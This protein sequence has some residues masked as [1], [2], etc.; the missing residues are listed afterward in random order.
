MQILTT[1]SAL[2][3]IATDCL[4]VHVNNNKKLN[5][6]AA[7][8]DLATNGLIKETLKLG[9]FSGKLGESRLLTHHQ[10]IKAKRLL[11]IGCGD[12]KELSAREFRQVAKTAFSALIQTQ[13]KNAVTTLHQLAVKGHHQDWATTELLYLGGDAL[14]EFNEFRSSKTKA[15]PFSK[16]TLHCD[17]AN[18]AATKKLAQK[19]GHILHG[20]TL[21][22]NLGNTP[23]NICNPTYLAEQAKQLAKEFD[24][25]SLEVIDEEKAR[26]MGMGSFC[27][28][29]QG[30]DTPGKII[31]MKYKGTKKANAQP[32]TLVGKG[33]TFD[34]GGNCIKQAMPMYDMKY[35]MCGAA[36]VFGVIKACAR[37]KLPIN[38]IGAVAAAENMLSGRAS[39]PSDIVK[40]YS[41][42]TIEITNTDAEGRLVLCDTLTY[43]GKFKPSQV[44]SVATLTGAAIT[45]LGYET[46]ALMANDQALADDLLASGERSEDRAWQLPLHEEYHD[47]LKSNCADMLN[48]PLVRVAGTVTSACF[49]SNFTRDYRWAH[50][51]IAGTSVIPGKQAKASGRPVPLLM[52]YLL[53]QAKS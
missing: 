46:T 44:I 20:I 43:I 32:I 11:L 10:G 6:V 17:K 29:A 7:E 18:N 33:I 53:T 12:A 52:D 39:R 1:A 15:K 40:S 37:L 24:N 8:I 3:Q 47:Y 48:C 26:K 9:D 22:K 13:S 42:Q 4:I 27:S 45:A 30:S 21:T 14:Y 2:S 5:T 41:G 35:D 25:I 38:V 31:I 51:D 49:L 50:L 16:L 23:P 36:T 28:V 19:I 34:T